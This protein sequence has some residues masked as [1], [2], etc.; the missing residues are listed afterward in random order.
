MKILL[1]AYD[2]D[3]FIHWFPH[4]L[5]YIAS[6]LRNA[7][8]EITVYNQDQYH[9]PE[10]HLTY[11]LNTNTFDVVGLGVIA[12]YY[13]YRK[14]LQ[15]SKAVNDA[16]R[17]PHY[18]L[19][20][21][22]PSPEPEYFLN[23][24]KADAII[25]G[26]GERTI[27]ELLETLV[28]GGELSSVAGVAFLDGN[29]RLVTTAPR[30]PIKENDAVP[31]PACDLIPMDYYALMREPH[32]R[33]GER[34][35]PVLSGRGCP[36][37]CNFCYRMDKGIRVRSSQSVVDEILILKK[38]YG[39]SY[40]AFTD[41]LLM[42]SPSRTIEL[43]EAFIKAELNIHWSCNGRLN[44]ATPDVLKTMKRSGCVFIGYGIE[45]LDDAVLKT[46][47]KQLTVEQIIKGIE[48]TL[49]A[50]ISPGFNVI[51][52]NI[53]ES[54]DTLRAG[55]EFLLKYDDHA[56]LRTIRPVTPYPGSDLY[57]YAIKKGLLKDVGEFYEK[58]LINS[59]LLSVNFTD[60]SDD[61]FHE[62][63]F[64]ANKKLLENYYRH[65]LVEQTAMLKK[66]YYEKNPAFRG[67]RQT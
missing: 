18:V 30:E 47:N 40:V 36:F 38:R 2:N 29:G 51:F 48:A 45:C 59:D 27:I 8:H 23:I 54:A 52:G 66:L 14:L 49:Q 65:K 58:R 37:T 3:S 24:S 62:H 50:G 11:F 32:I 53:G 33:I 25:I 42:S 5:A 20:G 9:Y 61:E 60:L 63:L 4:G 15:I 6:V 43:C 13:Q 44:Y 22:G 7:G 1:I 28:G 10:S 35:F 41:E 19:G 16:T 39:I 56:Q 67:F 21:H 57:Y 34:C 17:R 31:Y 64:Q 46:M 26:E 12:G 55:T